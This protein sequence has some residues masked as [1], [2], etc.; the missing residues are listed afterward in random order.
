MRQQR[1]RV[2]KLRAQWEQ[3][4]AQLMEEEK[5]LAVVTRKDDELRASAKKTPTVDKATTTERE[6]ESP[7]GG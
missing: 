6:C 5:L 1:D 3:L 2:E 4:G 7:R